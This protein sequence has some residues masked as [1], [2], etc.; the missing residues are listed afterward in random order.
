MRFNHPAA[1]AAF[2]AVARTFG[3]AIRV[4]PLQASEYTEAMPDASR[5]P[6]DTR[7]VVALS[8]MTEPF[9]GARSG[10]G[11]VN[12]MMRLAVRR[13]SVWFPADVYGSIGYALRIGDKIVM[14]DRPGR[15]TYTVSREPISSDRGDVAIN[16]VQEGEE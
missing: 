12:T 15:P 10:P 16:L 6:V 13:A 14:T 1:A 3:E 11:K 2:R 8:P 4:I 9:D 7:A 5:A